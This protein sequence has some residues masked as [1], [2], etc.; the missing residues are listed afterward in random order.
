VHRFAELIARQL[1]PVRR[2]RTKATGMAAK[3][4]SPHAHSARWNLVGFGVALAAER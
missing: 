2:M 4:V 1:L 3:P